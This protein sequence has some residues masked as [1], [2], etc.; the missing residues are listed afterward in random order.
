MS[1]FKR[2]SPETHDYVFTQ[3]GEIIRNCPHNSKWLTR[4]IVI[5][6]DI[7]KDESLAV[8]ELFLLKKTR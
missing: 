2:I 1:C 3:E 8:P 4:F 7:M 6:D 5:S